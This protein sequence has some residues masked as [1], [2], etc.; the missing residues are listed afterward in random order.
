MRGAG[1]GAEPLRDVVKLDTGG[2]CAKRKWDFQNKSTQRI[3]RL[4]AAMKKKTLHLLKYA[5]DYILLDTDL[6]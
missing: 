4:P 6:R 2:G 1:R 3:K 5:F